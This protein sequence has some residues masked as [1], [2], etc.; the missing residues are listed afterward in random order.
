M[1]DDDKPL[2]KTA[3]AIDIEQRDLTRYSVAELEQYIAS[4]EAEIKRVRDDIAKKKAHQEAATSF[5][6]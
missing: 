5:F 4:M 6:K 2:S 1:D 3:L